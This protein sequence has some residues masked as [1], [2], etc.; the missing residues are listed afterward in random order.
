MK[1]DGEERRWSGFDG[2]VVC[3]IPEG[4]RASVHLDDVS[5][6]ARGF[7]DARYIIGACEMR[8]DGRVTLLRLLPASQR[9]TRRPAV[10][11]RSWLKELEETPFQS[12]AKG[13][14]FEFSISYVTHEPG[15]PVSSPEKESKQKPKN[16]KKPPKPASTSTSTS[17][18]PSSTGKSDH[19]WEM[20]T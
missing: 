9:P 2:P 4:F 19:E 16:K 3:V 17:A 11:T 6:F 18:A 14:E 15:Q 20:L 7:H 10:E 1:W 13:D 5:V 8:V 12:I